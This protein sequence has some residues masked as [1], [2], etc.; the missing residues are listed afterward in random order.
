MS[1]KRSDP[2]SSEAPPRAR[3][4]LRQRFPRPKQLGRPER[5]PTW[6]RTPRVLPRTPPRRLGSLP[7]T[8]PGLS[9]TRSNGSSVT[10]RR[11]PELHSG[12]YHQW[13]RIGPG[14]S[15]QDCSHRAFLARSSAISRP[16]WRAPNAAM[17]LDAPGEIR[18][19]DL[20]FRRPTL[21]PAELRA[22]GRDSSPGG[23]GGATGRPGP[24]ATG[25]RR[26]ARRDQR[27]A[28]RV[29]PRAGPPRRARRSGPP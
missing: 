4:A 18:T 2:G 6:A 16:V 29:R 28:I 17:P 14:R 3:L 8:F 12:S 13:V 23:C 1:Q 21:Y 7:P 10:C 11:R 27:A 26:C 9:A 20:R 24:S 15:D 25:C 19:P 5:F 22:P